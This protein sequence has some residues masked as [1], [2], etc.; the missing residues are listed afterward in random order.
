MQNVQTNE[1]QKEAL[2]NSMTV[3]DIKNK[4]KTQAGDKMGWSKIITNDSHLRSSPRT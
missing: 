2:K 4:E 1:E 3:R